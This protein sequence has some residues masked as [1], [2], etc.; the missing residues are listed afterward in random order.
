MPDDPVALGRGLGAEDAGTVV[1]AEPVLPPG[2]NALAVLAHRDVA[3]PFAVAECDISVGALEVPV[4]VEGQLLG[5]QQA[6]VVGE[7]QVDVGVG[8]VGAARRGR[9]GDRERE[10]ERGPEGDRQAPHAQAGP[11]ERL[12]CG[13]T[14]ASAGASKNSRLSKPNRR[15]TIT[16]G[17]TW[18]RV[19]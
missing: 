17:K 3:D 7:P 2:A 13:A 19:L 6:A 18:I 11:G 16:A 5:D 14:S 10:R 15:A 9:G 12:I 1:A 4:V 8:D